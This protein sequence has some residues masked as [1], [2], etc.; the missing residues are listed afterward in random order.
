[1]ADGGDALPDSEPTCGSSSQ[2]YIKDPSKL[3]PEELVIEKQ[4]RWKIDVL[5]M[6]TIICV[7][8][9]NYIDRNNYAAAR[10]QGLERDLKLTPSQYQ[11]GLSILFVSYIL[12]QV[13][14]NLLLN[15]V[16]R[17]SLYLGFS[18]IAWGLVSASTSL[19]KNYPQILA[20]RLILGFVEAPFFAGVLFYLS[21]W[22]IEWVIW[23]LWPFSMAMVIHH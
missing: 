23:K 8:L 20:C 17:P 11:T 21:K 18:T 7:Y 6:P 22:Y 3:T 10:L 16:G 14:S 1:M 9:M 4:L 12:M 15:Y 19:V 13:P 2:E 5:I